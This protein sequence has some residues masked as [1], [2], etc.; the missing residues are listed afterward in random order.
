MIMLGTLALSCHLPT[1]QMTELVS[2]FRFEPEA[3]DSFTG[4]ASIRYTLARPA[5]TT[6]RIAR[7]GGETIIVLFEFLKE[8]KGNLCFRKALLH[9]A[10]LPE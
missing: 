1:Q 10:V 3:F 4:S 8:S 9:G 6:L 2:S 7:K 5:V